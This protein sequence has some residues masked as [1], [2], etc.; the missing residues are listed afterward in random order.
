MDVNRPVTSASDEDGESFSA[1]I[2]DSIVLKVVT[3]Y[4]IASVIK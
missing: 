1:K 4:L 3:I 2:S